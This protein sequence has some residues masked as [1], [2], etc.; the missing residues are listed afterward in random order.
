M[1]PKVRFAYPL[2]TRVSRQLFSEEERVIY[3]LEDHLLHCGTCVASIG[4]FCTKGGILVEDVQAF[5]RRARDGD[6]YST[7]REN[8]TPVRLE[9]SDV[10]RRLLGK[11]LAR[12]LQWST[13]MVIYKRIERSWY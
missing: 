5:V 6:F 12:R 13:V 8:N 11:I 7:W 3:S 4:R 10:E 9:V 2:V 1:P